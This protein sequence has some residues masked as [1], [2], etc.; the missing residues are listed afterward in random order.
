MSQDCM[1]SIKFSNL[2]LDLF[3]LYPNEYAFNLWIDTWRQIF[4]DEFKT[5]FIKSDDT[6]HYIE[7]THEN[8]RINHFLWT[9]L[10]LFYCN[11]VFK[12]PIIKW[13]KKKESLEQFL[14]IIGYLCWHHGINGRSITQT[15]YL[16]PDIERARR[17]IK[18]EFYNMYQVL[19][20]S[21]LWRGGNDLEDLYQ[22]NKVFIDF[23]KNFDS[24]FFLDGDRIIGIRSSREANIV[25][26][27]R[28]GYAKN[29]LNK[30]V[31][32]SDEGSSAMSLNE[33]KN[34]TPLPLYV[35]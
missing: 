10:R 2:Y 3:M 27:T 19:S 29:N 6:A 15:G 4:L 20:V 25:N 7:F 11:A 23:I 24:L 12:G 9:L 14:K 13:F 18:L 32:V 30:Y 26:V 34:L 35:A 28:Y 5:L 8:W 33:F 16:I 1:D 31:L 17:M 21:Y 22:G